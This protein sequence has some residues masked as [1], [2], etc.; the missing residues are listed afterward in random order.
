MIIDATGRRVY[1]VT[2]MLETVMERPAKSRSNQFVSSLHE[3][4]EKRMAVA[5]YLKNL[6]ISA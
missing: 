4:R 5:N 3:L 1:P 2:T 6:K